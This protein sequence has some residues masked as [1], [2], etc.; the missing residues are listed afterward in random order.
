MR[1]KII[2]ILFELGWAVS[3]NFIGTLTI[4][5]LVLLLTFPLYLKLSLFR[6]NKDLVKLAKIYLFLLTSQIV[7]ECFVSNG[8]ESSLKGLAI[9]IVSFL[10]I[11]F[12][13]RFLHGDKKLIVVLLLAQVVMMIARGPDYGAEGDIE[14]ALLGESVV[15]L[16]FYLAPLLY[17]LLPALAVLYYRRFI[18][19]LFVVVGGALIVLGAR[20][21][22]GQIAAA[23]I[24]VLLIQNRLF[25][26][27][28]KKIGL[29]IAAVLGYWA[30]I[31]YIDKV[32]E[33]EITAGNASQ[34]FDCDNP[35][36]PFELLMRGRAEAWVGWQA[37]LDKPLFGHGAWAID[38]THHY[39]HMIAEMQDDSFHYNPT[40]QYYVP[41]HSL[42][43]GFG[44]WNGVFAMVCIIFIMYYSLKRAFA[45]LKIV[46][47]RYQLLVVSFIIQIIW[48]FLFSPNSHL[49]QTL[50]IP[51]AIILVLYLYEKKKKQKELIN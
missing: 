50:P 43:I 44:V 2:I 33:G 19:Y 1:N 25:K 32:L 10:H 15:W 12:L 20:S 6:Q 18:P 24:I 5:E 29:I 8:L 16:K 26:V 27:K 31:I 39:A 37:F 38:K 48:T 42:I 51:I 40:K 22:G 41:G 21:G 28:N 23:G 13:Y 17:T 14:S 30:Y 3:F 9:T 11:M 49:R 34:V 35:Y 4:S 45:L 7:S 46:D 47:M 36:N